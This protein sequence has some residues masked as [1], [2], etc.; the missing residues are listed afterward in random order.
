MLTYDPELLPEENRA[1]MG[2]VRG[3]AYG[4]AHPRARLQLTGNIRKATICRAGRKMVD[5]SHTEERGWS[6]W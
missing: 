6:V 2:G 5:V 1:A 4:A 3:D